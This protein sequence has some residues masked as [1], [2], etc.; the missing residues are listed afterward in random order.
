MKFIWEAEDI[1]CGIPI[2]QPEN[3]T[4]AMIGWAGQTGDRRYTIFETNTD[5]MIHFQHK[6]DDA[7]K[8]VSG[9]N[10]DLIVVFFTREELAERLN[11]STYQWVPA[12]LFS[13]RGCRFLTDGNGRE[14]Q[15]MAGMKKIKINEIT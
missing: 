9:E 12:T 10:G 14:R 6:V 7:G 4:T 11:Q 15:S 13:G 5:G 3:G 2:V 1:A 8:P